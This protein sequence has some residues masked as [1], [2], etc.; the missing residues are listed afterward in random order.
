MRFI[1][2]DHPNGCWT[3]HWEDS[4]QMPQTLTAVKLL[5][6]AFREVKCSQVGI[7]YGYTH[8]KDM[9]VWW[10]DVTTYYTKDFGLRANTMSFYEVKGCM[11]KSLQEA[12]QFKD[13][14]EKHYLM[15][16]LQS[17]YG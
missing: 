8:T 16:L 6:I 15:Q 9:S 7:G 3:V 13:I 11:F 5:E 4:P 14:M 12:E 2:N 10:V 1:L 17:N